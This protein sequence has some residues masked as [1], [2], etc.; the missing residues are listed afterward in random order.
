MTSHAIPRQNTRHAPHW[1]VRLRDGR[2]VRIRSI[3]MEDVQRERGLL[4]RLSPE[5]HAYRFL[6]L[7]KEANEAV[8]RELTAVDPER[9]VVLGAFAD[10]AGREIEIGV[11]RYLASADGRHCDCT[12]TVD[13]AWHKLGVGRAL[14]LR[15]I[16]TARAR[17]VGRMYAVD[18]V[19]CAGAHTL[20]ERLGFHPR[21]DPEDPVVTT[22]ELIL[23]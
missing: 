2:M 12:V 1:P 8:A 5:M 18:A 22:F 11:A 6:G 23:E 10:E 14:M 15:L 3:G 4:S 17:G 20:A 21:P 13:P 9:E 16:D 19:R 7:I